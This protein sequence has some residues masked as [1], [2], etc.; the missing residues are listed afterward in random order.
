MNYIVLD[1]EWNQCPLGKEHGIAQLPFE[2]IEIGAVKLDEDF[3]T[4][5]VFSSLIKPQQYKEIH[6]IIGKLVHIDGEE[7][8]REGKYFSD[9]MTEFFEWCGT[10]YIFV[11]WGDRDLYILQSNL[12][13]YDMDIMGEEPLYFYDA[14]KLFSIDF[15]DG[16]ER[17]SLKVACDM[18]NIKRSGEF[19]RALSDA[20]YT[21]RLMK[22]IDFNKVREY[23][24]IDT[25][26]PPRKEGDEI[27]V[28]YP[29]YYKYISA[30]TRDRQ[31]LMQNEKLYKNKCYIC[32]QNLEILYDWF[33]GNN[34]QYYGIF[35]CPE[36][37]LIKG[38]LRVKTAYSETENEA[39]YAIKILK[40]TDMSGCEK[41][42][43]RKEKK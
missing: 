33:L 41:I 28:V 18:V 40:Q 43:A 25:Y 11:T 39:Y 36:H 23:F 29:T 1:I 37:G 15:E 31:E 24:S 12:E 38:R 21:A 8:S 17:R 4:I 9:V 2:I 5:G 27:S 35:K 14:Q 3:N 34:K 16:K 32:Q 26:N 20:R 30:C 22:K 42:L 19:H 6:N 10:D 7:L 13:F